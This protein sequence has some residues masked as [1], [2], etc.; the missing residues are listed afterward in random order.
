MKLDL[1]LF[2]NAA[3]F[4][5]L[6]SSVPAAQQYFSRRDPIT[7][8]KSIGASGSMFRV[9]RGIERP[10]VV[11]QN[12]AYAVVTSSS[13]ARD[14]KTISTQANFDVFYERLGKSLKSHWKR[15]TGAVLKS[16]YSEKLL[17]VFIKRACEL[18][19]PNPKLNRILLQ[20]GHVPL[21]SWIF[22]ALDDLFSGA[23]ML[24]GRRMGHVNE[25]SYQLFQQLIRQ[26]MVPLK[27]PPLYFEYFAWNHKRG[28]SPE[29]KRPFAKTID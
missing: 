3:R 22:N 13:F 21:D 23:L 28:A 7:S 8:A 14:V 25:T 24:E 9:F 11:Y 29:A 16:P 17:D 5:E 10:S 26:I 1:T 27:S 4:Q 12:W 6:E 18:E 20:Y 2:V 19:L 15:K